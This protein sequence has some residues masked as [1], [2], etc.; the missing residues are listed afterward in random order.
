VVTVQ[1]VAA[2]IELIAMRA[3]VVP[4]GAGAAPLAAAIH[5]SLTPAPMHIVCVVSGGNIDTAVLATILSG[6][7]P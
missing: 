6:N 3:H 4:E 2:A 1:Q 7:L 5:A